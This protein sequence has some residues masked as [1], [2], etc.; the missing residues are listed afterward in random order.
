MEHIDDDHSFDDTYSANE[1]MFGHPYQELQDFFT[2][3][4]KR[5]RVLDLG[6]GQ[7]RDS[8]FLSSIGFTVT[9]V[10]SSKIGV[11]QM[12]SKV[13]EQG[14]EIQGIV[15]DVLTLDLDGRYDVILFDM[16]LHSFEKEQQSKILK[17][18]SSFLQDDGIMCIVFPDDMTADHFLGLLDRGGGEWSVVEEIEILDVPV[19]DGEGADFTFTMMVVKRTH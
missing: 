17:T 7:G 5:G 10:D 9:A 8:L 6:C 18:F 12:M 3:Y 14:L 19:I 13:E 1:S 2:Q 16:L 4:P 15:A 11:E